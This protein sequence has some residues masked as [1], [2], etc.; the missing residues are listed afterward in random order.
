MEYHLYVPYICIYFNKACKS[1]IYN[2]CSRAFSISLRLAARYEN[3]F[4][5]KLIYN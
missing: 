5:A 1:G 2:D 4:L 3:S